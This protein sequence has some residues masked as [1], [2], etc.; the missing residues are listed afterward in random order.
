MKVILTEDVKGQGK[1]GDVID[2]SDGFARNMIIKKN[3]GVE[4]TSKALNDLKLRQQND[5]KV[6]AENL[7]QAKAFAKEI[8]NWKVELQIK[9]GEGGRT[10]GS[11]SSKE[12][13][14]AVKKQYDKTIDKK[15]IVLDEPIKAL[16]TYDVKLKLHPKVTATMSVHVSEM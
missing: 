5:A 15:K 1:K 4:A 7:E 13:A 2:V 12:I 9:T 10:F 3:L 11:I 14:E 6:A 8:E 16:G